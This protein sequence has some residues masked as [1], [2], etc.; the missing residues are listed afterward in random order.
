MTQ[1]SVQGLLNAGYI[2]STPEYC[3]IEAVALQFKNTPTN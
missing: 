2:Y 1:V 3:I